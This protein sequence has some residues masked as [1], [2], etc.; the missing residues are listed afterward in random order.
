M[1]NDLSSSYYPNYY[2]VDDILVT[3]EKV[4][5]TVN[6]KLVKMGNSNLQFLGFTN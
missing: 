5:C 1:T 2:S 6:T 3:Q 4:V